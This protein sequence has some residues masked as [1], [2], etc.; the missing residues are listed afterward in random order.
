MAI[1]P[2]SPITGGSQTGFSSPTYTFVQDMAPTANGK[3]IAV[4][5]VGGTQTGVTTHSASSPFTL[6]FVRPNKL[7]SLQAVA[8]MNK[9]LGSVPLNRY[10]L[11]VRKGV[12]VLAGQPIQVMPIEISIGIPAGAD[13]ADP[14]NVRAAI[15]ATIGYLSQLSA[16]IGDTGVT[17]TV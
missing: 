8:G 13:V 15:S 3:Q 4:T 1:S 16:G 12:T 9:P 5:A 17:G 6:N 7:A 10:K 14:S 2:T 11:I